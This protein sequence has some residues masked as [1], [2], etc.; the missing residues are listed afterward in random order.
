LSLKNRY[1]CGIY[2]S[3]I[4]SAFICEATNAFIFGAESCSYFTLLENKKSI[5]V[6]SR[7]CSNRRQ[8]FNVILSF[9][10]SH[11]SLEIDNYWFIKEKLSYLYLNQPFDLHIETLLNLVDSRNAGFLLSSLLS[12]KLLQVPIF[13]SFVQQFT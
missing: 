10:S 13:V 11:L 8:G 1:I 4:R 12:H 3:L 9:Y 2:H 7:D 6:S 5:S